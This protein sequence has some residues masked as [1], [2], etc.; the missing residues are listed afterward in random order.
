MT[1]PTKKQWAALRASLTSSQREELKSRIELHESLKSAFFWTPPQ[2][3]TARRT[4]EASHSKAPLVLGLG[5][6]LVISTES[7]TSCSCKNVYYRLS[8]T[9]NGKRSDVRT[10]R[11]LLK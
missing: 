6:A 10:L 7:N 8:V 1:K 11:G 3:A 9:V 5:G 2:L 4:F